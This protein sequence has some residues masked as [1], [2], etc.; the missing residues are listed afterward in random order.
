MPG[1]LA[2]RQRFRT[3]FD[4]LPDYVYLKGRDNRLLEVNAAF[5]QEFGSVRDVCTLWGD[6]FPLDSE[7]SAEDQRVMDAGWPQGDGLRQ[8]R[9]SRGHRWLYLSRFPRTDAAGRV[10]GIIVHGRE[11][12]QVAQAREEYRMLL[13]NAQDAMFLHDLD[14]GRFLEVNRAAC[15]RLGYAR[16]EL[17]ALT[18]RDIDDPEYAAL[19]PERLEVLRRDGEAVFEVAHRARDGRVIPVE[20]A[21]R[22]I[23]YHG[24]PVILSV[25][26]DISRHKALEEELRRARDEARA[27]ADLLSQVLDRAREGITVTDAD[28]KI[29]RVNQAFTAITGYAAEEALGQNPRILKSD[30]H[31]PEFY[32]AM[33]EA[34]RQ[35]GQW[36]G[37]I[38]NRRKS[39]EAYPEWL[40]IG[41]VR[42]REGK[43][44]NYVAVFHDLSESKQKDERL[45]RQAYYDG[46]T[47]LPNRELLLDRLAVAI[48]RCERE[49]GRVAL[50]HLDLDSFKTVNE[51]LGLRAG[52]DLLREAA[53][54][55]ASALRDADTVCRL[56]GDDFA[57]LAPEVRDAG[58]AM[59]VAGRIQAAFMP[60]VL[61]AGM[62]VFLSACL[63]VTMYPEDGEDPGT[64]LRN[65]EL[66]MY[67]AKTSG[68]N[69]CTLFAPDMDED[70]GR[71]LS[72]ESRLRRGLE[73]DEIVV[74]CQPKVGLA[75]GRIVGFEALARW[76]PAQGELISPAEFI[77]LAEE[78]GLILPLGQAV[79]DKA[80]RFAAELARDGDGLSVA[81][82]LS[83]RQFRQPDLAGLVEGS[84]VRAGL[85]PRLLE[86]EITESSIM[87][88]VG[89]A[90]KKLHLLADMGVDISV[91]D[92]GTGYSSLAY[93]KHFP[94][95]ELKVDR[96]FITGLTRN[97]EDRNIVAAVVALARSFGLRVVAEGVEHLS[98]LEV[99]RSLD[100]DVVQGFIFGRPMPFAE[101]RRLVDTWTGAAV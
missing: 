19:V 96:S 36:D 6:C 84:L 59:L 77:P 54:R 90:V 4:P 29:L 2:D 78:T 27:E 1:E 48:S 50:L 62:E 57:V 41:A 101:F 75:T 13:D 68:R 14:G 39:G 10:T 8:L 79:L 17:L 82:N 97:R 56:G 34:L 37:E 88:E 21:A 91:D 28:S 66:A 30:R 51:S 63:G 11:A 20:I 72:L 65:A 73:R 53:R 38:W 60:P 16:E 7:C 94:I 71:K 86:V 5:E 100:C 24:Q 32:A 26:R 64:L 93:L 52:D 9:T 70:V 15:E 61:A 74:Y 47:G 46:L 22:V 31:A 87:D 76:Q 69:S 43:A 95:S 42:D 83:P 25:A 92:F 12:D 45:R 35:Q 18:P 55:I 67:R 58:E 80:C 3:F 81:V 49:G 89:E 40:S 98:Q 23:T 33:W 85:D 99:V 44:C